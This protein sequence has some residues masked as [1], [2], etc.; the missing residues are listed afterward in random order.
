M[1]CLAYAVLGEK[2]A[3]IQVDESPYHHVQARL[4]KFWI[5]LIIGP[6]ILILYL[7]IIGTH[8]KDRKN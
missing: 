7:V 4:Q 8:S 2:I 1:G 3:A 5:L 6:V